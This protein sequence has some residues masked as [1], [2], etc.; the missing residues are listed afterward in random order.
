MV[1]VLC[2]GVAVVD[3]V[4]KMPALP[5]EARKYRASDAAII[6]GGCAA[7]AAVAIARLGGQSYVASRL[8]DDPLADLIEDG[9]TPE[10]VDCRF[11]KR[12][13]GHRSAFSSIYVDQ[14]GER[15]IVG[16][17][18]HSISLDAGWLEH[19]E[20]PKLD[21]VLA[22][23]R[24]PDGLI[25][26]MRMARRL[27]VPGVVDAET[28][29]PGLEEQS[30]AGIALASHVAFSRNGLSAFAGAGSI[31][32]ELARAATLTPAFVFVTNGAAGVYWLEDGA[33]CHVPA[34]EVPTV[35]TLGAGDIWH[36]AFALALAR[37]DA[38]REA[39][40]FASAVAAIKCMRFGGRVGAPTM[41][42]VEAF[43][44]ERAVV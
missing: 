2:T 35:D 37:G 12:F 30:R 27:G 22:D 25:A 16:Y 4:F 5:R 44:A 42:E 24:W 34:F 38:N 21:A 7:N 17:R 23:N 6:G 29:L 20:L 1:S 10:G 19:A 36:G 41:T 43:L 3:F 15:Q 8:G 14:E 11:L 39:I 18:D 31:A 33:L 13:S 28:P 9:L 32:E 26:S 40:R